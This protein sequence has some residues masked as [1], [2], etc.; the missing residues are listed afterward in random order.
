MSQH[1][2]VDKSW[3]LNNYITS[4]KLNGNLFKS[5]PSIA[6]H[7]EI[8]IKYTRTSECT[9]SWFSRGC[10]GRLQPKMKLNGRAV[11]L[12][13][14]RLTDTITVTADSDTFRL[15]VKALGS[16]KIGFSDV[17]YAKRIQ[18]REGPIDLIHDIDF[19]NSF[20]LFYKPYRNLT[21]T[22]KS[23][24][25]FQIPG[26]RMF[27]EFISQFDWIAL[28]PKK[29]NHIIT[30]PGRGLL[31][32][33]Q[34]AF[35]EY[36]TPVLLTFTK[37]SESWHSA[38]HAIVYFDQFVG[39]TFLRGNSSDSEGSGVDDPDDASLEGVSLEVTTDEVVVDNS[40]RSKVFPQEFD[41]SDIMSSMKLLSKL[42]EKY[43]EISLEDF[44][45]EKCMDFNDK[46]IDYLL[47]Q[48]SPY[49]YDKRTLVHEFLDE[50]TNRGWI[51]F[52]AN[53][54]S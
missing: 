27:L 11:N 42:F 2:T 32:S 25:I 51:D 36:I 28:N 6:V 44:F 39:E 53:L 9:K 7:T 54:V 37:A 46:I 38:V 47:Y 30:V 52:V 13:K 45:M 15:V 29:W 40:S 19:I 22:F 12:K 17:D 33:I 20:Q 4:W 1:F 16:V 3:L 14:L 18:T 23:L 48:L 50:P 8:Y 21:E 24:E 31:G 10:Y 41:C 43:A 26:N 34:Q 5:N 35:I 49:I